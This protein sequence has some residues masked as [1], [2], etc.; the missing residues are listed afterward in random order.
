[1]R[2]ATSDIMLKLVVVKLIFGA[3]VHVTH[4]IRLSFRLKHQRDK[5]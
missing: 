4:A 5:Y 2:M 1:M 3:D